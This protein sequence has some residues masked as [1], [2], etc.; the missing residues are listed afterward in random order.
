MANN[1]FLIL[2]V[3]VGVLY[4]AVFFLIVK[5]CHSP[6]CHVEIEKITHNGYLE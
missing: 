1:K 3:L 6:S 2:F 5:Y 4:G